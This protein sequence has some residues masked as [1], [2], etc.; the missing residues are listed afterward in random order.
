M[1]LVFLL[2]VNLL[3][4]PVSA[5]TPLSE[6]QAKED[7]RV[8]VLSLKALHPAL[9]KYQSAAQAEAN[10]LTF[11]Q[12][13]AQAR[14][15]NQMYLAASALA[16]SIRCGHTWTNVLNQ[17]TAVKQTLLET[18]NKLPF[19]LARVEGRWLVIASADAA[20]AAG[21]EVLAVQGQTIAVVEAQ[22]LPYLR[23]DGSSDGKRWVQLNHDRADYSQL[24][25]LL[26]LLLPPSTAGYTLSLR[27][28][29]TQ[30]QTVTVAPLAISKRDAL[31]KAQGHR[32][33]SLDWQFNITGKTALLHLPN[34]AFWRS[35]F[36][37]SQYLAERFAQL[38][39]E[40][41]EH[42]IID[43]R[44]NEGGSGEIGGEL[45]SYLIDKP[46]SLV[47]DQ[48]TS[49]Y[50]RVPYHLV[51]YLE[52]WDYRF[53]DRTGQVEKISTGP[54]TGLFRYLPAVNQSREIKP[55]AN[56][57][58]GKST[59]LVGPENSSA[60]FSLAQT[61]QRLGV[62][63]LVGQVT[64]G[65]QRG[66]N[67]GAL[68]WVTLPNSGVSVDIPLLAASYT[69]STPD[70]SL[71]PDWIIKQTF[72]DRALGKDTVLQAVNQ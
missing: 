33:P 57:F 27:K 20:V 15:S 10:F 44:A 66:L 5:Q 9:G 2:I 52:T 11:E 13:A 17:R 24:D 3:L 62:A 53:F 23:A 59:L 55:K 29:S 51:K 49:A 40:Q 8:L 19:E 61:A 18:A 12:R 30:V 37:W 38:Q 58:K 14:D 21:D 43:I 63:R 64:G 68:T 67:G 70:A 72:A 4:Q 26:P 25:I 32:K 41:I 60:T 42:L 28:A 47:A 50:E 39:A 36:N 65:N 16:A 54:A 69:D 7:A 71:T 22:L 31:L 34:F 46:T 35:Q 56:R 48:S 45:L 6:A 1:R